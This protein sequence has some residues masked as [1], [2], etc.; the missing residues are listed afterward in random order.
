MIRGQGSGETRGRAMLTQRPSWYN[1]HYNTTPGS[2]RFDLWSAGCFS[3]RN[4]MIS[5]T[6]A[7][8]L[9]AVDIVTPVKVVAG[10]ESDAAEKAESH[11]FPLRLVGPSDRNPVY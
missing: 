1:Q 10:C 2:A 6:R 4:M 9:R 3:L 5:L 8:R 7:A 11:G